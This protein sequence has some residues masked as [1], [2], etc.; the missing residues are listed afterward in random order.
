MNPVEFFSS[1]MPEAD[2]KFT[3]AC[4]IRGLDVREYINPTRGPDG[5]LL[6]TQV[7]RI[8]PTD[9][10]D[11]LFVVSAT[12]GIEG[13]CGAGIQTGLLETL[14][15]IDLPSSLAV[16]MVHMINPW[17][18]AWDKRE[19]EDNVDVFRNL[20]YC[21]P[22]Y[23]TNPAYD[24]LADAICPPR[25]DEATRRAADQQLRAYDAQHGEG[26][27][28]GAA[29]RGQHDHPRG[30]TYHGRGPTWSKRTIDAIVSEQ[31]TQAQRIVNYDLHTGYGPYGH[32]VVVCFEPE[33]T[34]TSARLEQWFGS[35]LLR[36]GS[37]PIIPAH[38]GT[39]Y[40]AVC[41]HLPA[42]VT[43]FALEFGTATVT[44]LFDL[45]REASWVFNYG[46]PR[47]EHGRAVRRAYR[48]LFYP[49]HDDW[50]LQVWTRGREVFERAVSA[51]AR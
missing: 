1:T 34:P 7:C 25:W 33:G 24:L 47:S 4:A 23:A 5:E 20:L 13:Y 18:C 16:V 19:N 9:A 49:E 6:R 45:L 2:S 8:G 12:H 17:G 48:E 35:D 40:D 27:W 42:E 43:S 36:P 28:I 21:N 37:D 29:R 26:A 51:L 31:L 30:L 22:P 46:D 38:P 32:G 15:T 44:D 41:A 50:K 10:R 39:P 3:A 14:P 11:V